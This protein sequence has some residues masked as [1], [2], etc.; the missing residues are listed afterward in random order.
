MQ[1]IGGV[2]N[3]VGGAEVLIIQGV[4]IGTRDVP[5]EVFETFWGFFVRTL[6]PNDKEETLGLELLGTSRSF[7][8]WVTRG[9]API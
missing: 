2:V 6:K 8:H 9:Q 3:G 7:D 5:G 1:S 4:L